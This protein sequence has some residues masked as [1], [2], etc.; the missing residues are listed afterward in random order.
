[1]SSKKSKDNKIIAE[2]GFKYESIIPKKSGYS[3]NDNEEILGNSDKKK[4]KSNKQ[5]KEYDES[6]NEELCFGLDHQN[7]V[8]NKS[9]CDNNNEEIFMTGGKK[10]KKSKKEKESKETEDNDKEVNYEVDLYN[11]VDPVELKKRITEESIKLRKI[12]LQKIEPKENEITKIFD[13]IIRWIAKKGRMIIIYGSFGQNILLDGMLYDELEFKDIDFYS[14]TPVED[15]FEL[16]NLLYDAGFKNIEFK[17]AQ[18]EGTYTLKSNTF[19]YCDITYMPKILHGNIPYVK[20]NYSTSEGTKPLHIVS[21]IAMY[22]D[23][24]K[25]LTNPVLNHSRFEKSYEALH[26]LMTTTDY[27]LKHRE[28]IFK[29]SKK[30]YSSERR[31]LLKQ[32][33]D[34]LC[35]NN[36]TC[37]VLGTYAFNRYIQESTYEMYLPIYVGIYEFISTNYNQDFENLYNKILSQVPD[38]SKL[39][40]VEYWPF[41][42]YWGHT[43]EV[44]YNKELLFKIID[45]NKSSCVYNEL[46]A[47]Y[48]NYDNK[49]ERSEIIIETDDRKIKIGSFLLVLMNYLIWMLKLRLPTTDTNVLYNKDTVQSIIMKLIMARRYSLN[50]TNKT[51]WDDTVFKEIVINCIGISENPLKTAYERR[52]AKKMQGKPPVFGYRP[53][54]DG[55]KQ[56]PEKKHNFPNT[57]GNPIRDYDLDHLRFARLL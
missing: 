32:V 29:F 13:I 10:E 21:P 33:Y 56:A 31:T 42:Q 54:A 25:V 6:N 4:K 53:E 40:I 36:E 30:M 46:P 39:K 55:Y 48:Y 18:H 27:E 35:D 52:A 20:H 47:I 45:S 41:F 1:M 34:F 9:S 49:E 43:T 11:D 17:E 15:G 14:S 24:M 2:I 5:N 19:H 8:Q 3:N 44:Y 37:V 7:I 16:A 38:P 50:K 51:I 28:S 23:L 22:I 26:K 57:S 12:K